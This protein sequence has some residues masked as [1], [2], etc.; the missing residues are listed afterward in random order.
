MFLNM[1]FFTLYDDGESLKLPRSIVSL[2]TKFVLYIAKLIIYILLLYISYYYIYL[3]FR[4][5]KNYM[6]EIC[7]IA[8]KVD[9][10]TIRAS[11][12]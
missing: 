11:L 1:S 10:S 6:P 2:S 7:K 8:Q 5:P 12:A 3:P 9:Y 4:R